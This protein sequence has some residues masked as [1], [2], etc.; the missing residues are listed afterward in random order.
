[1]KA[2]AKANIFLK[3][4]GLDEKGYHLLNS[5]FILLLDLFDE[6]EF[7]T[8]KSIEGFE[9]RS[10]FK[11][12]D[13]LLFKAYDLLC[14]Y[15]FKNELEEAFKHLSI[16]LIK[17]IPV[18]AGLGGGSSDAASFLRLVNE[19]LNLNISKE[20]L[21]Q[22]GLKLGADVPFFLS[23][24]LSANVGRVGEKVVEFEDILPRLELQFNNTFCSTPLIYKE[25]DRLFAK[26][27]QDKFKE[28][29]SLSQELL[30]MHSKDI[31]KHYKPSFLNDLYTP[32]LSLYPQM[33]KSLEKGY[34]LSGSGSACFKDIG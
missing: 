31:L 9:I 20:M 18:G 15:G 30:N 13:N 21:M 10:D 34:F 5:R 2:H 29:K 7:S 33:Q 27:L 3:I 17:N 11:C 26:E 12:E 19:E 6:L 24:F 1:M 8:E 23:G 32:C 28:S 25:F 4:I 22:I 16:K 14:D